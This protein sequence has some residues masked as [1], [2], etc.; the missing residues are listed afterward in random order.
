MATQSLIKMWSL[1]HRDA[2]QGFRMT[3]QITIRYLP[4]WEVW[5]T[6]I[7]MWWPQTSHYLDVSQAIINTVLHQRYYVVRVEHSRSQ[8][9][10]GPLYQVHTYRRQTCIFRGTLPTTLP[11]YLRTSPSICSQSVLDVR[12]VRVIFVAIRESWTSSSHSLL[13]TLQSNLSNFKHL[14]QILYVEF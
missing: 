5:P 3:L 4:S 2:L 13:E 11:T 10:S 12:F 14:R 9:K 6:A 8:I 7:A 1:R